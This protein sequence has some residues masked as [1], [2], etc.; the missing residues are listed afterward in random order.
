MLGG[1]LTAVLARDVTRDL[2]EARAVA[3]RARERW[4]DMMV[5]RHRPA[6]ES[7]WET[8]EREEALAR[9]AMM[10]ADARESELTGMLNA[11]DRGDGPIGRRRLNL[12]WLRAVPVPPSG[13]LAAS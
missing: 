10:R 8:Y 7:E 11:G 6:D 13:L 2:A 5:L 9:A 12:A 4:Q 1:D 3:A